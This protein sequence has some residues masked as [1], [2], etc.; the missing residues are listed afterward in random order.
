MER[1][2]EDI[3]LVKYEGL[4]HGS[5][6]IPSELLL[7]HVEG[8]VTLLEI[9]EKIRI[10]YANPGLYR[11]LG[12]EKDSWLFPCTLKEI[13]L[14]LDY[15]ADYGMSLRH[16]AEGKAAAENIHRISADGKRWRWIHV[17]AVK[18]GHTENGNPV[19]LE[20]STDITELMEKG[21]KLKEC[22]ERLKVAYGQTPQVLWE[23]NIERKEYGIYDISTQSVRKDTCISNFPES[24]I[25][26]GVVHPDSFRQFREFAK[27]I[28][29]GNEA[30]SGN[31]ILKD[32][33]MGCYGWFTLSYRMI[34]DTDGFPVK[35]VGVQE[36]FPDIFGYN[37]EF[38]RRPLPEVLRHHLVARIRVNLTTD[39]VEEVWLKGIDQ[40]SAH[41]GRSYSEM[42]EGDDLLPFIKGEGREFQ[43]RFSRKNLLKAYENSQLWSSRE[44]HRVANGG[45]I[46]WMTDMVNL[47]RDKRTDEI[48]MF[49]CFS[50]IQQRYEWEQQLEQDIE[51]DIENGFYNMKTARLLAEMLIKERKK[52][53][54]AMA[55]IQINGSSGGNQEEVKK[56][57]ERE[58]HFIFVVLSLAIGTD[59]IIGQYNQ[60]SILVFY[61]DVGSRYEIKTRLE[62]AFAYIRAAMSSI[63]GIDAMRLVAGVVTETT[64][65]ADY[66]VMVLHAQYLCEMWK[67]S[68]TDT[69][70]L[71]TGAENWSWVGGNG[72]E[73]EE[74][75]TEEAE[76]ELSVK[77]QKAALRCYTS[78][79]RADSLEQSVKSSMSC[80]GDYYRAARV[81]I[82]ALA[83]DRQ[84][85]TIQ[86]EWKK[87][88]KP[89]IRHVM[90]GVQVEKIP[91]LRKCLEENRPVFSKHKLSLC[92]ERDEEDSWNFI[93]FPTEE[94]QKITGFLCVENPKRHSRQSSLLK[95]VVPYLKKEES[96][97]RFRPQ[98]RSGA[99][100]DMVSGL[101]NLRA[102]KEMINS[103]D[104]A[105]YSSM[106]A[107][108]I[109]IPNISDINNSLGFH[110]GREML[111]YI[112]EALIGVFGQCFI[113][114]TWDAEFVILYPNTILEVF[115]G[116]C[117]R[118]R[119][120]VQ[121][122]YPGEIRIGY[123]W[124]DGAFTAKNLVREARSIM[125]CETVENAGGDGRDF[126]GEQEERTGEMQRRYIPY[127]QP[128]I[129]MRNGKLAGA[130]ALVRGVDAEGNII[131]PGQFIEELENSGKIRDLDLFMLESVLHQMSEWKKKGL[132]PVR[133]SVNMSRV[134]LFNPTILASVLAIQSHY[135]EIAADQIELE[136]TETA[137][138]VETAPLSGIVNNFGEYGIRFE[139]DDFGS[140]Y[141]NMTVFSNIKFDTV[142]LDRSLVADLPDNEIS[143]ML[144]ENIIK[145]CRNVGMRCVA[146]G[147]ETH[148]Q[149]EALLKAG[150][151]Y[152]QGYYYN[153]PLP[154]QKF[155][156]IY[157]SQ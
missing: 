148:R 115:V 54:C 66:D 120:R 147:V 85:V 40:T 10:I 92:K 24:M 41:K 128:K 3:V 136:I 81:Y 126:F 61:P 6:N 156:E 103:I 116:R 11:I 112:V 88:G 38:E 5:E 53:V 30:G 132:E 39:Q 93:V 36:K 47:V 72:K 146:E 20:F 21:E 60:D 144:V 56:Q 75:Q 70:A 109:D 2:E 16:A 91:L 154:P 43:E 137:G 104:S 13:G 73:E 67:N 59:C 19:M 77:E 23:V 110:Y 105:N 129:D 84:T 138:D 151:V 42:I 79:L 44:Y 111:A 50:D 74:F 98:I 102:C 22:S 1:K 134:T 131:A 133:V 145:I 95:E 99:V 78:M 45:Q 119:S 117:S 100:Q 130:E 4:Q 83:E 90:S 35:A 65:Q 122:R 114:R 143:C 113:F 64:E 15:E 48:Y 28:L 121:R 49:A 97:F 68:A 86:Y 94:R 135:P 17:R 96:R 124:S 155:E 62:D 55:L 12:I 37:T 142:K 139:L 9:G 106:G 153:K 32:P 125:R 89:S 101:P 29:G 7:Q 14:Q 33:N 87:P 18:V 8:G 150:C 82:L 71:P 108:A 118:L 34:Y 31:F 141:A 123:T 127:F 140:H 25:E 58:R 46:R 69:V 63:S 76:E 157:L 57:E 149:E 80:I 152:G 51:H 52:A 107:L 26:D 27:G